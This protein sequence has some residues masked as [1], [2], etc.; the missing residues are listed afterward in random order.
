M[1]KLIF[2]ILF[3]FNINLH[4]ESL[5]ENFKYDFSVKL[6]ISDITERDL[7]FKYNNGNL[8]ILIQPLT[9]D[10]KG[11]YIYYLMKYDKEKKETIYKIENQDKQDGHDFDANEEY[12]VITNWKEVIIYKWDQD[13]Y[14]YNDKL[15][16]NGYRNF[17]MKNNIFLFYDCTI[18]STSMNGK[19]QTYLLKYD[20]NNREIILDETLPNPNGFQMTFF[21]PRNLIEANANFTLV[22]DA[23]NYKIKVYNPKN[24]V[25]D[26]IKRDDVDWITDPSTDS[27]LKEID[28]TSTNPKE[29][30]DKLRPL[31][32]L[33]SLIHRMSF[34]NDT[35]F[36]LLWSKPRA[37]ADYY[38]YFDI[39][40]FRDGKW[41]L[42]KSDLQQ[43]LDENAQFSFNKIFMYNSYT[44]NNS[45][46]IL[47]TN[48]PFDLE[49][50]KYKNMTF[51]ELK[52]QTNEYYKKNELSFTIIVYE[53][54]EK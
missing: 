33:I 40:G 21:Q 37:V 28:I 7:L 32:G 46:L 18:N 44:I 3:L 39:W 36:V 13:N 43:D 48:Y 1:K 31:T 14:Y 49:E 53:Y 24:E 30:I 8:Y 25:F 4:S 35:T 2:L 27:I 52:K 10:E 17:S 15:S 29:S 12:F 16:H 47:V 11:N 26:E 19:S 38:F 41:K 54:V 50:E 51:A 42:L 22:A 6:D 45:K 20:L 5:L 23:N 9:Q 34:I